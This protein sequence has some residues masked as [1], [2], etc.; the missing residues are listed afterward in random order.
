MGSFLSRETTPID[1]FKSRAD[2]EVDRL[3]H[4]LP[5]S[6]E[7]MLC[8]PQDLQFSHLRHVQSVCCVLVA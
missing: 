6:L 3:I 8:L 4:T 2:F 7:S 5:E 1:F